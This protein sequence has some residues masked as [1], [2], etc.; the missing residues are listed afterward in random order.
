MSKRI[1]PQIIYKGQVLQREELCKERLVFRVPKAVYDHVLDRLGGKTK[2]PKVPPQPAAIHFL[3]YDYI[4]SEPVD[5]SI[6]TIGFIEEHCTGV[7]KVQE[8]FST[9]LTFLRK[10]YIVMQY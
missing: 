1:I 5:G 8:A 6:R 3:A 10:I 4:E 2:L 7:Y 9:L